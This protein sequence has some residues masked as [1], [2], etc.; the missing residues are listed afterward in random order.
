MGPICCSKASVRN[1]HYS[2]RNKPEERSSHPLRSGSLK[3]HVRVR[4]FRNPRGRE[5]LT[6]FYTRSVRTDKRHKETGENYINVNL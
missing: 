2:L 5:R 1:D 3:S 4:K 6:V